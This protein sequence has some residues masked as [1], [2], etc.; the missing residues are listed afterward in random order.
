VNFNLVSGIVVGM[1]SDMTIE[2]GVYAAALT[3]MHEDFSCDTDELNRHCKELLKRGCEGIVLFGTTGEGASFSVKEKLEVLG[4]LDIDPAKIIVANGSANVADTVDLVQGAYALGCNK[5]LIG[6]PSYF[7]NISEAGVVAFYKEVLKKVDNPAIRILLYHIP[8]LTGVPI[9]I[10]II[11]ELQSEQVVGIKE[12]EGNLAFTKEIIRTFPGF[13]VFVGKESQIV[14]AM[15]LGASGTICGLANLFP[16]EILSQ[17]PLPEITKHKH[18]IA[19]FKA[20]MQKRHGK[21]W[22]KLRPPLSYD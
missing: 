13:K 19:S 22:Q 10:N 14:E 7:K 16:D 5:A 11:R 12:S 1:K 3:P 17:K 15:A 18:F 4:K 9:T 6:P 2:N 8:Q 20:V 21:A